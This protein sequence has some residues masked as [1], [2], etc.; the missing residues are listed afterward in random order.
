MERQCRGMFFNVRKILTFVNHWMSLKE[1]RESK[2]S[3]KEQEVPDPN[4]LS[5]SPSRRWRKG[6]RDVLC[7]RV[8]QAKGEEPRGNEQLASLSLSYV[9][10]D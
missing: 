3:S 6:N 5:V 2:Q 4:R 1:E 7:C 8:L 10:W 9:L